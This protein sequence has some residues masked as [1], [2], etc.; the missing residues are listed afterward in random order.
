MYCVPVRLFLIAMLGASTALADVR[1][2]STAGFT[3]ENTTTVPV[4][5]TSAWKALVDDVDDLVAA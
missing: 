1:D 5:P 2:S 3:I 4:D